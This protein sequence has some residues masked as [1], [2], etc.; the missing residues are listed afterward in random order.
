MLE[1]VQDF[2]E[3]KAIKRHLARSSASKK[4]GGCGDVC[5]KIS[6]I[7]ELEL[8]ADWENFG[9]YV[10]KGVKE[11]S[12]AQ[13]FYCQEENLLVRSRNLQNPSQAEKS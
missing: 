13:D 4:K 7:R 1:A 2:L 6:G 12:K 8:F 3:T 9:K 10:L 11:S 5:R